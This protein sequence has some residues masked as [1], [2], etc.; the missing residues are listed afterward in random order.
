MNKISHF[1]LFLTNNPNNST[2][3]LLSASFILVTQPVC[4]MHHYYYSS[5][6]PREIGHVIMPIHRL[7]RLGEDKEHIQSH[8]GGY[9][10]GHF[11]Y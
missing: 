8:L 6:H 4:Y 9:L 3:H 10:T 11:N 7:R 1:C 5:D 2:K